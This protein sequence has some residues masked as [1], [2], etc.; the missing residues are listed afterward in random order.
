MRALTTQ[1]NNI[2]MR[3]F[4]VLLLFLYGAVATAQP[5]AYD[6]SAVQ[7]R[8]ISSQVIS[9]YRAEEAFQ[10]DRYKEPPASWWQRFWQWFWQKVYDFLSTDTG[11]RA[12]KITLIVLAVAVL[13]FFIYRLTG[14]NKSGLFQR[15]TGKVSGYSV[16][17]EDIHS[18]P[19]EQAIEE[20]VQNGN[21]RL[22][23]RLLYLQS[24]KELADK[25]L[26]QW[27][28]NKTNIAYL[29]ELGGTGYAPVFSNLTR[30]FENNWYGDVPIRETEFTEVRQ[31]FNQFN[32]QIQ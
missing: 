19:F 29:Q 5:V 10:Y 16:S 20:A 14:M 13:L 18:I 30:Q 27:Q 3:L 12:F 8:S 1:K 15:N 17:D 9:R 7:R 31:Q 32:R 4:L 2:D 26:I 11:G 6:S 28:V 23:V 22:A 24:L 21:Y 25:G